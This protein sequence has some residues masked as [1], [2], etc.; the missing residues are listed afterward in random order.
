MSDLEELIDA[1]SRTRDLL[2]EHG[3][4]YSSARVGAL[5]ERLAH[6]DVTAIVSAVS[7]VTGGMGSLNDFVFGIE[8]VDAAFRALVSEVEQRARQAAGALKISLVR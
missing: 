2:V 5:E 8:S 3:E 1:L 4:R 7:E 6:Q